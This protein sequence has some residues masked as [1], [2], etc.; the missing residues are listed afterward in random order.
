MA[1]LAYLKTVTYGGI[2]MR[3]GRLIASG[4]LCGGVTP[5]HSQEKQAPAITI[6]PL[7]RNGDT[8]VYSLEA[9][10]ELHEKGWIVG[11]PSVGDSILKDTSG[12]RSRLADA[13]V[14]FIV[15]SLNSFSSNTLSD[16][17]MPVQL[18]NG[19][20]P[21]LLSNTI[22]VVTINPRGPAGPQLIVG[23]SFNATTFG[24]LGPSGARL[25]RAALY[26]PLLNGRAAVK[27]GFFPQDQDFGGFT[28]GGSLL[29]GTLGPNASIPFQVGLSRLGLSTPAINATAQAKS[30]LYVKLGIQ[31]ST[32]PDGVD[33]EARATSGG[34]RIS[35][36]GARPLMIGEIGI[37][38]A[39]AINTRSTWLRFAVID[40]LSR[41]LDYRDGQRDHR[42]RAM[43][44]AV[45]H[46]T[47]QPD[48]ARPQRGLYVGATVMLADPAVNLFRRYAEM[49]V[50]AR[51]PF[52]ARPDDF[53][54]FVVNRNDVSPN[55]RDYIGRNSG[56][57][58][59]G[60]TMSVSSSYSLRV[61]PGIYFTPG[62]AFTK[63]PSVRVRT[64]N[65][66]N[67]VLGLNLVL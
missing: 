11:Y 5:A 48:L 54:S 12:L 49:R 25:S 41:Y 67:T 58:T 27:A 45:D 28:V 19:Q 3:A 32:S 33:A 17:K 42:N 29:S 22:A 61:S 6:Q 44:V 60:F 31:R 14:G 50:Y 4:L 7:G 43:Y 21:T 64:R 2:A 56:R 62:V 39:A 53:L 47:S 37:K 16:Q 52:A 9:I 26:L 1:L 34:I 24:L 20:R 63:N 18:F 59:S 13:G 51:G 8:R 66:L 65:A 57:E 36:R 30:G 55:A 10:N 15:Y 46:Q 40:N 35:L 23:G 38:R